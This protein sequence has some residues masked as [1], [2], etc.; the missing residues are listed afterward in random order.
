[1]KVIIN[2]IFFIFFILRNLVFSIKFNFNIDHIS[3]R[4][5][6]EYLTHSD[7]G[8]SIIILLVVITIESDI[9]D[10]RVRLFDPNGN[11]V[12]NKVIINKIIFRKIKI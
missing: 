5:L 6:A 10:F 11:A 8:K 7:L 3:M 1:M 9:K 2:F 4:C 12:I